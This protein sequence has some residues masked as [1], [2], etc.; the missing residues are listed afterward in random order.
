MGL[1]A[2]ARLAALGRGNA[3]KGIRPGF[4]IGGRGDGTRSGRAGEYPGRIGAG[5]DPG[6]PRYWQEIA[7]QMRPG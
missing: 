6:D 4:R 5:R 2:G 1:C 3:L 7:R